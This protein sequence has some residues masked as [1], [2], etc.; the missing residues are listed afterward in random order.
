[1]TP[2]RSLRAVMFLGAAA[3]TMSLLLLLSLAPRAGAAEALGYGELTRFGEV[4]AGREVETEKGHLS[5]ARTLALGVDGQEENSVFVL[6]EPKATPKLEEFEKPTLTRFFRL[7]KF[8][9]SKGKYSET[10]SVDFQETSPHLTQ[11]ELL[12]QARPGVNGLVVD[13]SK[14]R[15]YLLA[16]DLRKE[17]DGSDYM[18]ESEKDGIPAASTL[19][20]FSTKE[21]GE[22]LVPASGTTA[23]VL[24]GE[25]VLAPQST[26]PG[27]ALLAPQGM[28]LDPATGELIVLAHVDDTATSPEDSITS[29]TDHYV[30]Q[31]IKPN[32]ELGAQYVDSTNKFKEKFE[33]F[34]HAPTSPVVV[35]GA[36]G[37]ATEEHVLVDFAGLAEIP[38]EFT[39]SQAPHLLPLSKP[40]TEKSSARSSVAWKAPPN[41]RPNPN[42]AKRVHPREAG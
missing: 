22:K 20:A 24:A 40:L 17:S 10:A 28:T 1:M 31:R 8:R 34:V 30:L 4:A 2:V 23:G 13:P 32:G 16:T 25:S 41:A 3:C 36:Q 42:T 18:V 19:Y 26:T 14:E 29:P 37:K 9:L 6:E 21:E 12:E 5:E 33:G 27:K 38:E 15:V 39:S 7:K 11:S 35:P